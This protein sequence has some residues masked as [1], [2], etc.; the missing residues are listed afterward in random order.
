MIIDLSSLPDE[1][2][3][4]GTLVNRCAELYEASPDCEDDCT[5]PSGNCSGCCRDCT[6]QVHWHKKNGR[7]N[8]NEQTMIVKSCFTTMSVDMLGSIAP[9]LC[10]PWKRSI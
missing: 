5:H 9:K 3:L 7:D 8:S 2:L 6:E 10:M 1:N 4:V